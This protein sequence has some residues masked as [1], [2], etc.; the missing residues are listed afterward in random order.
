MEMQLTTWSGVLTHYLRSLGWVLVA[1]VG[2]AIG[3]SVALKIFTWFSKD[4]DEWEEIKKGNW[5]VALMLITVIASVAAL[6][7]KVL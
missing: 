1:T 3:I 2:F 6:I 4:I 5:A 7:Y